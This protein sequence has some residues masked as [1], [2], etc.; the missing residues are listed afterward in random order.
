MDLCVLSVTWKAESLISFVVVVS[1][2]E[3][4]FLLSSS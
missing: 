3:T 1:S 4:R 2:F